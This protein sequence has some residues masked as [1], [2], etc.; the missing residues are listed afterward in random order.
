MDIDKITWDIIDIYFRDNPNYLTKHQ[1]DSFNYFMKT[2]I[3]DTI[4]QKNPIRIFKDLNTKEE[5]KI[6]IYIGN[7]SGEEIFFGLPTYEGKPLYPN[8]ARLRNQSY[9]APL[10]ANILLKYSV[11]GAGS[12]DVVLDKVNIGKIPLML[13]SNY[14]LLSG[15]VPKI[16]ETMGESP[17]EQGGYFVIGGK[18]KTVIAQEK[19]AN[20][21]LYLSKIKGTSPWSHKIEIS[22][23]LENKNIAPSGLALKLS[24]EKDKISSL[25]KYESKCIYVSLKYVRKE[26]PLFIFFRALGIES[27]KEILQYILYDLDNDVSKKMMDVLYETIINTGPIYTQQDAFD[28]IASLTKG[29]IVAGKIKKGES[30]KEERENIRTQ[31]LQHVLKYDFLPHVGDSYV[32]KAYYLGYM[33]NQLIKLYLGLVQETDKDN[34]MYKRVNLSGALMSNLF[35]DYYK[36]FQSLS[37][38]KIEEEYE[39]H[40]GLYSGENF[41]T[42][43]ND[44]NKQSYFPPSI[45]TDGFVTSLKG[46][47]GG[48]SANLEIPSALRAKASINK[49]MEGVSQDLS[50]LTYLGTISHLRRINLNIDRT[51]KILPPRRLH[52]S[53]WGFICPVETPE[54]GSIGLIKS[55]SLFTRVSY[56]S[57]SKP[58]RESL[59]SYGMVRKD[60]V[61]LENIFYLTKVFING[62]WIGL[63]KDPDILVPKLRLLKCNNYFDITTSISWII[64]K[65]EIHI[66]TDYGRLCRP[67]YKVDPAS[68]DLL[69]KLNSEHYNEGIISKTISWDEL[70]KGDIEQHQEIEIA[71]ED[72]TDENVLMEKLKMHSAPI[73]YVDIAESNTM[74]FATDSNQ[75]CGKSSHCEIHPSLLLGVLGNCTPFPSH[76]QSPRNVYSTCQAKQG[77][78]TYATNYHNRFDTNGYILD[79]P[80]KPL[81]SNR[82]LH[83]FQPNLSY[84]VNTIV[85]IGCYTGYNV[86]DSIIIN[87]SSLERGLFRTTSFHI[88]QDTISLDE[89]AFYGNPKKHNILNVKKGVNYDNLDSNGVIEEETKI[90]EDQVL[91][92]KYNYI[93][94]DYEDENPEVKE[95]KDSSILP[96][97]NDKGYVDK[98]FVNTK[99]DNI[100]MV[101]VR[102]RKTRVPEIGDKFCS[103]H[104]QKGVIG[105]LLE[106]Q[107]MP[108]T[109]NGLVPDI[110]I[111]PHAIPSRMTIGHLIEC[112]T[113]KACSHLGFEAD[114]T[115]FIDKVS[116][117]ENIADVLENN[118]N[119]ERYG[120][121]ILYNGLTGK[122]LEVDFFIGP[123]YY[124]RLKHMV[125][126]KVHSRATGPKTVLSHQPAH[127]RSNEGGLRIGEMERDAILSHG[128][129]SYLKESYME[130]SDKYTFGVCNHTGLM[131]VSNLS[132]DKNMSASVD[133]PIKYNSDNKVEWNNHN[134]FNFSNISTPFAFKLLLQEM[135]IMNIFPRLVT[136]N[137]GSFK[138]KVNTYFEL[139]Q[140]G[141]NIVNKENSKEENFGAIAGGYTDTESIIKSNDIDVKTDNSLDFDRD[142]Y[143]E[144]DEVV[145]KSLSKEEIDLQDEIVDRIETG[146]S[147]SDDSLIPVD[148]TDLTPEEN[149]EN[150]DV[151]ITDS[152]LDENIGNHLSTQLQELNK[153]GNIENIDLKQS[154]DLMV[155]EN[156]GNHISKK[157]SEL[158]PDETLENNDLERLIEIDME[159]TPEL[160]TEIPL[161]GISNIIEDSTIPEIDSEKSN[162]VAAEPQIKVIKLTNTPMINK[163]DI[164]GDGD[165]DEDEDI[166]LNDENE[167]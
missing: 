162:S 66:Q 159:N 72:F 69:L 99:K 20:N 3:P 104:G 33:A 157:L 7:K 158:T 64:N 40:K 43:L 22:S 77:L 16:L 164:D 35:F 161:D 106:Q 42:L 85:A 163:P 107:D 109:R 160:S 14:C 97:K 6:E 74:L 63:H 68:G 132:E 150:N 80:Q 110:I 131:S 17:Y 96:K 41:F 116:P 125:Q 144:N 31:Y 89:E 98:V 26:I 88:Y 100:N 141:K 137:V 142:D 1:L 108:F 60:D 44:S 124:L 114:S 79:Y 149:I 46:N 12:K 9:S 52:S 121:E 53:Q 37:K 62:N 11:K 50:R 61:P 103:R 128:M 140:K 34:L 81:I 58:I 151:Y 102:I 15:Q 54:G 147:L 67:M 101:K 135:E 86:E 146:E 113:G 92:G 112:L 93:N 36:K 120:N 117:V 127:G 39:Y 28:Y 156:I 71:T 38:R 138:S 136:E 167:G 5:K 19:Q 21:V 130:K 2:Q 90:S 65:K 154:T 155:D 165:E 10:Y 25:S 134:A 47:W 119:Y 153:E 83:R 94:K 122:Q 129:S 57:D 91:I 84:G 32:D 139:I 133:G 8:E 123:T 48:F 148:L 55:I 105:M 49:N 23:R 51:T 143:S 78:G 56:D 13:H 59:F 82:Y 70:T 166:Y 30:V 73:E 87:K 145:Y 111:N 4:K 126:D 115:A 76:N 152:N 18:E 118:C 27:D 95:I 45:I 75:N 29:Q 24:T